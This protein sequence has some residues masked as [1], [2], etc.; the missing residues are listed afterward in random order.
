MQ[1]KIADNV[2]VKKLFGWSS[3][4]KLQN[5]MTFSVILFLF[6][7]VFPDNLSFNPLFVSLSEVLLLLAFYFITL[8][9]L[10]F[11]QEKKHS[12][13]SIIL[14][15]GILNALIFFILSVISPVFNDIFGRAGNNGNFLYSLAAIFLSFLFIVAMA[16]NF[17][18]F[19]T[20]FFLKQ[21]RNPSFYFNTMT[22]FFIAASLAGTIS[23][24]HVELSD[25]KTALFIVSLLLI[26][27][28]SIRTSWIAFLTKK[29]KMYLLIISVVMSILFGINIGLSNSGN[30]FVTQALTQ[31]S[32]AL[33]EFLVLM[34]SYG[35][36]YFS[37][38]FFTTLFHMPTA[39]AFDRK[40]QEVSSLMD[41]SR[42]MT[43]VFDFK[44]LAE[45]V[46]DITMK[47][48]NSDSAWLVSGENG[49]LNLNA[50]KNIGYI[51]ADKITSTLSK[52]YGLKN[53]TSVK[54]VS[55]DKLKPSGLSPLQGE[56]ASGEALS[57]DFRILA[58]SP[59]KVHDEINGY[60]IAAR[61]SEDP[62]D[63][64]DQKSIGAFAD[65]AAVAIEQA[66]LLAESLEKERMEKELD[67][68]REIQY[69]ILPDK[70][71]E[72]ENMQVS[73]LFVPAFEVGGDYY[74]FFRLGGD[75]LGFVIADVSGKGI[76]AAFIMAEVKG[77]FESLARLIESPREVLVKA[78][79]VL[80]SSL[81]KKSFVTVVYGVLEVKTGRVFL[82]RAGHSPV[83]LVRRDVIEEVKPCGMGLGLDFSSNFSNSLEETEIKLKENDIL[84]LYTDGIPESKNAEME[85]FGYERL[86]KVILD[87]AGAPIDLISKRIMKE[88]AVFSQGKPQHDDITLV[89][90]KWTKQ[91]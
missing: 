46:T 43:Q 40:A 47:V 26:T 2:L 68:A 86:N 38:V 80:R 53:I 10:D 6:R 77:I 66:K 49:E 87:N 21:K 84:L 51:E 35:C 18:V 50:V 8:Y 32:P 85:D 70:T 63:D 15:A 56:T 62:F 9:V 72:V 25:F 74:D 7:L 12:P 16:Y 52:K 69:K 71:P 55:L 91:N 37:V 54:T 29:E 39:E 78:N 31:F 5:A 59:L 17:S 83:L 76:P 79:E 4:R 61:K 60:L 13:L 19:R 48:C 27:L 41:L 11:I 82:S 45:T 1:N 3:T 22:G 73:A 65:Y 34:M 58:V 28:N 57:T 30:L 44:E 42:L 36:I 75:R 67:V 24:L 23:F 64:D 90:F 88:V 20:L 81:D 89:I 33:H 14:N